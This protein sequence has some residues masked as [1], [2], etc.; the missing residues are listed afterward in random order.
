MT[1]DKAK[2]LRILATAKGSYLS[3]TTESVA[4]PFLRGQE[5]SISFFASEIDADLAAEAVANFANTS[6][7]IRI[8]IQRMI[9][10]V[11][12][13]SFRDCATSFK[14]PQHQLDFE[15]DSTGRFVG[16]KLPTLPEDIWALVS[17]STLHIAQAG[18]AAQ[19]QHQ[20]KVTGECAWDGEH[21]INVVFDA[22]GVLIGVSDE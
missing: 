11:A 10:D 18:T 9:F 19:R 4:V 13:E 3:E 12:Q 16:A 21:G 5:L 15:A 2:A 17:F 1:M 22:K 8:T 6:E 20:V 14:S 7:P